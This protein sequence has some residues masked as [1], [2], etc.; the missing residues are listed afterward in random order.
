MPSRHFCR[1]PLFLPGEKGHV[2]SLASFSPDAKDPAYPLF[3]QVAE[4]LLFLGSDSAPKA[5]DVL[6]DFAECAPPIGNEGAGSPI[7]AEVLRIGFLTG[8]LL[9]KKEC[10]FVSRGL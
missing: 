10:Q 2:V 5:S 3:D 9:A 4:Y 6:C 8:Y 1:S 7:S